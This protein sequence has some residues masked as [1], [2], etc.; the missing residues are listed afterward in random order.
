MSSYLKRNTRRG[1]FRDDGDVFLASHEPILLGQVERLERDVLLRPGLVPHVALLVLNDA[2]FPSGHLADVLRTSKLV[3]E[4]VERVGW[5]VLGQGV[6][7]LQH[8]LLHLAGPVNAG[9][10]R[11]E[12]L[13]RHRHGHRRH[14]GHRGL[15]FRNDVLLFVFGSL[16]IVLDDL[17]VGISLGFLGFALRLGLGSLFLGAIAG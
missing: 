3:N 17:G 12:V 9:L 4:L 5:Q 7:P 13:R 15:D 2:T 10:A 11:A 6:D 14:R 1:R 16:D 8:L